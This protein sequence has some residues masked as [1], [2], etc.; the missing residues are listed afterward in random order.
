MSRLSGIDFWW[1]VPEAGRVDDLG[2][3]HSRGSRVRGLVRLGQGKI[4]IV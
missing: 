2:E 3:I 4:A 1:E